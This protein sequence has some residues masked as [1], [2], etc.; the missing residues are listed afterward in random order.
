MAIV[1]LKWSNWHEL[2]TQWVKNGASRC[3]IV[4]Q[5]DNT[6]LTLKGFEE[7]PGLPKCVVI[8]PLRV[9]QI[10]AC[11]WS[12]WV[13]CRPSLPPSEDALTIIATSPSSLGWFS[14]HL[15]IV[16]GFPLT[17]VQLRPF[18]SKPMIHSLYRFKLLRFWIRSFK[19]F[20]SFTVSMETRSA[21]WFWHNFL[22]SCQFGPRFCSK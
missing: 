6:F 3:I 12:R 2:S 16:S 4:L 20:H 18:F 8:L 15:L 21:P 5:S 11:G 17:Q 13:T 14:F 9:S 10:E 7:A 1:K 22:S 19:K